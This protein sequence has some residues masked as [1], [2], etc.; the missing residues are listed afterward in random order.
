MRLRPSAE[1]TRPSW[2]N[3]IWITLVHIVAVSFAVPYF[4]WQAVVCL[5]FMHYLVGM[6]GITFGF[7]RLLTHKAFAVPRWLENFTAFVGTLACQ[8]GPISWVA[9][10]R[11]HHMYSDRA[12]DPHDATR[13]FWYSHV[14]WI[15]NRRQDLDQFEEFQHYA[16]DLAARPFFRFLENY[17]IPIQFAFGGVLFPLGGAVGYLSGTATGFD[18]HMAT[19]FIVYG[20]FIRLVTGYHVTWFVNSAAHAWGQTPNS[21]N[22]LSKNSWWVALVSFGEGWHNNH[23]AQPRSARHGWEWWQFDQTWVLI[24]TLETF[25]LVSGIVEPKVKRAGAENRAGHFSSA[26]AGEAS[27]SLT[28]GREVAP[29]SQ[30]Q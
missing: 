12:E 27:P 24:R 14:G 25:G 4:S 18:W 20:T 15:F 26:A 8:G 9:A 23:H 3:I 7:H 16:P 21:T 19:A 11:N 1:I 6:F 28:L 17:M 29:L 10:H 2:K 13:G 30:D 5:A 22:D